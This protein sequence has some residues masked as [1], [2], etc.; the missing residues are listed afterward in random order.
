METPDSMEIS[1]NVE[2]TR[3]LF[4]ERMVGQNEDSDPFTK[5]LERLEARLQSSISK[6]AQRMDAL[7][8]RNSHAQSSSSSS[9]SIP[10][11]SST[12]VT[13]SDS[14]FVLS[15][16]L[17]SQIRKKIF[18]ITLEINIK[19]QEIGITYPNPSI[20]IKLPTTQYQFQNYKKEFTRQLFNFHR[21]DRILT[22]EEKP[23]TQPSRDVDFMLHHSEELYEISLKLY[24]IQKYIYH[25]KV[26]HV[27]SALQESIK[28]NLDATIQ[29]Q[30][31]SPENPMAIWKIILTLYDTSQTEDFQDLDRQ[32]TQLTRGDTESFKTFK[33]RVDYLSTHF[34]GIFPLAINKERYQAK[35]ESGLKGEEYLLW[36]T[37]RPYIESWDEKVEALCLGSKNLSSRVAISPSAHYISNNKTYNNSK[38]SSINNHISCE[39]CSETN[40]KSEDC[41][42]L[43]KSITFY[44]KLNPKEKYHI[45]NKINQKSVAKYSQVYKSHH[46]SSK[47]NQYKNRNVSYNKKFV[48]NNDQKNRSAS[49][50]HHTGDHKKSTQFNDKKSKFKKV[51]YSDKDQGNHTEASDSEDLASS[52]PNINGSLVSNDQNSSSIT[53]VLPS[54]NGPRLKCNHCNNFGHLGPQCPIMFQLPTVRSTHSSGSNGNSANMLSYDDSNSSTWINQCY[55]CE[56]G[57]DRLLNNINRIILDSGASKIMFSN[58]LYFTNYVPLV[59]QWLKTAGGARI[60]IMGKGQVGPFLDCLHVPSLTT[61]LIGEGF[62]EKEYNM[63]IYSSNG[64]RTIYNSDGDTILCANRSSDNLYEV[65]PRHFI[66]PDRIVNFSYDNVNDHSDIANMLELCFHVETKS[67]VVDR[68]HRQLQHI[69]GRRVEQLIKDGFYPWPYNFKPTKLQQHSSSCP[70]CKLA[71]MHRSSFLGH[72]PV[73]TV[74]G[75]R[76]YADCRGPFEVESINTNRYLLGIIDSATRKLWLYPSATKVVTNIV[77][78]FLNEVIPFCRVQHGLKSFIFQSDN[79]EF[80]SN[81]VREM[82]RS[83]GGTPQ[84]SSAYCPELQSMIERVWRTIH[85]MAATMLGASK[86]PEPFWE[87]A[88]LYAVQ[89]YNDLPPTRVPSVGVYASPNEK[90]NG[91]RPDLTKYQPFGARAYIYI[92]IKRKNFGP[93]AEQGIFVGKDKSSYPGYIIY[94]PTKRDFVTTRHVLIDHRMLYDP[95]IDDITG[96]ETLDIKEGDINDY[97]YLIGTVHHDDEDHLLYRTVS[98]VIERFSSGDSFIVGYRKLVLP[99]GQ[100][101]THSD[102]IPIHVADIERMTRATECQLNESYQL[103][104]VSTTFERNPVPVHEDTDDR[105]GD[106]SAQHPVKPLLKNLIN[107]SSDSVINRKKTRG[108]FLETSQRPTKRFRS[109]ASLS[110]DS[111]SKCSISICPDSSALVNNANKSKISSREITN[112]NPSTTEQHSTMREREIRR[113]FPVIRFTPESAHIT[114]SNMFS[115]SISTSLIGYAAMAVARDIV[116]DE[117]CAHRADCQDTTADVEKFIYEN[118]EFSIAESSVFNLEVSSAYGDCLA[119]F[120]LAFM[121]GL[122]QPDPDSHAAAMRAFDADKW[123][124]A[125]KTEIDSLSRLQVLSEPLL[126]PEGARVIQTKWVY[127]RKRNKEGNIERHRA[128]LVAK[129][130]TQVFGEDFFDTYAPVARLTTLRIVY[131]LTVMLDLSIAGMDVDAAFLNADLHE[132]LYIKAPVGTKSLPKGYVYKLLKALYGLKQAPKEWNVRLNDFLVNTCCFTRLNTE[133]CLYISNNDNG[134]I[135]VAI[136]VDDLIVAY[137]NT[138]LL[139]SFKDNLTREYKIRDLG[140]LDRALNMEITRTNDGGLFLSQRLYTEDLL[141]RFGALSTDGKPLVNKADTPM[142]H[143]IKFSKEG[144]T[145]SRYKS[146]SKIQGESGNKCEDSDPIPADFNYRA[147]VGALLWLSM[148]TRPDIAYAVSQV[149]K[150][151]S[152]PKMAH[153]NACKR[154][155][156]YLVGTMDFG[157]YYS[158][159]AAMDCVKKDSLPTGYFR[160]SHL[161]S[162][163]RFGMDGYVDADFA[164]DLDTRRS[165]TGYVFMLAGGPISWQSRA[166]VSTALSTMEAEYM[167]ASAA[168]Q[169]A[170]WLRMILEELGISLVQPLVL[171]ED[172]RSAISFSQHPGDHRRTKH[173]DYRHHFVREKV[174]SNDIMLEYIET[175]D[176]LADIFTKA[177]DSDR[178]IKLRNKLVVSLKSLQ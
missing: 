127:K 11:S 72:L 105:T 139:K 81:A 108:D 10:V 134:Y 55:V 66:D 64:L 65:D 27:Y 107:E 97:K 113:R 123:S 106:H 80:S 21:L 60:P 20:Y 117:Q 168:T 34:S 63:S 9:S 33:S 85:E 74:P 36:E 23:P 130:F 7:D 62:L 169:E 165:V 98:V 88:V 24:S 122:Q 152:A 15:D 110:S 145:R 144:A 16:N 78:D 174:Q 38:D 137:S 26:Y 102:N 170:L 53:C 125:E 172:N 159:K 82:V 84:T 128:R 25:Q 157:I 47:F 67:E 129:G 59:G 12:P 155:L 171:R 153:L 121:S 100:L 13:S 70:E 48:S 43:K 45:K 91:V 95:N 175:L 44:D 56:E 131:A 42:L 109:T 14:A 51:K 8:S 143:R 154:I 135:I 49:D 147:V 22:G 151:S 93:R 6:V 177:L 31:I 132:N 96:V 173:I 126:L 115:N 167:A 161:A 71:K 1:R 68:L 146:D 148:G 28:D 92:P 89:L 3:D 50:N 176:Q 94:R 103:P 77:K 4:T 114:E 32:W 79:G 104:G 101:S 83:H 76:F 90:Y 116:L 52:A 58:Y 149:A 156:R 111:E 178:F 61:D 158:T 119:S 46:K 73:E 118:G 29:C 160:G 141:K 37:W 164:N 166:Q 30:D 142:D 162:D 57:Q 112:T 2:E 39:I 17:Q 54:S 138:T 99:N 133:H 69:S 124:E 136:Y 75:A 86:L 150:Y 140:T 87:Y 5:A 163:A 120:A 18:E 40:H 35:I 19:S 41:P